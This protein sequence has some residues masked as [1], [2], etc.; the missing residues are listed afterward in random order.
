MQCHNRVQRRNGVTSRKA[1]EP[2][3]GQKGRRVMTYI[4]D[5]DQLGRSD[6]DEAGGKGANLG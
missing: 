6:L 3:P 2:A 5:F 4:K 1:A